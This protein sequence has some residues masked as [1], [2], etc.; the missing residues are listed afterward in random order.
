MIDI[1][2]AAGFPPAT[3]A[4]ITNNIEPSAAV[5]VVTALNDA[6]VTG[7]VTRRDLMRQKGV[8]AADNRHL[9]PPMLRLR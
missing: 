8:K 2:N 9:A 6:Y 7:K 5:E 4:A 1:M 3:V